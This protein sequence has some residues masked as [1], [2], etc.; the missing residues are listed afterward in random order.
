MQKTTA[1]FDGRQLGVTAA[2]LSVE[3][4]MFSDGVAAQSVLKRLTPHALRLTLAGR[5]V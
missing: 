4:L 3:F 5:H 1:G 2:M